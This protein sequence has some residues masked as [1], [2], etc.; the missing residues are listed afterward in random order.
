MDFRA[1]FQRVLDDSLTHVDQ[2]RERAATVLAGYTVDQ[3]EYDAAYQ[4]WQD[5]D[6]AY[7]ELDRTRYGISEGLI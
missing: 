7:G 1:D 2:L 6:R 4:I 5:L 3:P